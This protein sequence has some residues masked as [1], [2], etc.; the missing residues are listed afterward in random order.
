MSAT[1]FGRIFGYVKHAS[2]LRV[3]FKGRRVDCIPTL[4]EASIED[5]AVVFLVNSLWGGGPPNTTEAAG[6]EV[7]YRLPAGFSTL[8][9]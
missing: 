1:S 5:G 9:T 8:E 6:A 3:V 7:E 2:P 4:I